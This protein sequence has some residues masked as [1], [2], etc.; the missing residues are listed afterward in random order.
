MIHRQVVVGGIEM[1]MLIVVVGEIHRITATIAD[2]EELHEAHQRVGVSVATVLLVAHNLLHSLQ[3]RHTVSLQFDLN[4]WQAVNQDDDIVA[5]TAVGR[6]D[7]QLIHHLIFVLAP[8]AGINEVV[9]E[10]RAVATHKDLSFAQV[11]RSREH[12]GS[13]VFLQELSEFLIGER[14][15][16]KT[17]EFLAEIP[18]ECIQ[19]ADVATIGVVHLL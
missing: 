17:L 7:G 12:I 15:E 4:Q 10:G 9:V 19:V 6:V 5:L 2:D 3:W 14:D 8:V 11:F 18:F 1:E 13:D 16:I